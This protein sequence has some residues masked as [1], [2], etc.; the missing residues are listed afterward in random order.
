MHPRDLKTCP[1]HPKYA[2]DEPG[3]GHVLLQHRHCVGVSVVVREIPYFGIYF[4]LR[5]TF[6]RHTARSRPQARPTPASPGRVAEARQD[7]R[8]QQGLPRHAAVHHQR[9]QRADHG[10]GRARQQQHLR[11]RERRN[12]HLR[13]RED[14][15]F[16]KLVAGNGLTTRTHPD[17]TSKRE[18]APE[19]RVGQRGVGVRQ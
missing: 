15:Y 13:I 1:H 10:E 17:H 18:G 3:D 5:L 2:V 4:L 8:R 7:C 16:W 19:C 6:H 11:R 12:D 9:H 14:R